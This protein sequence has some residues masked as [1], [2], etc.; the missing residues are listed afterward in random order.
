MHPLRDGEIV[1]STKPKRGVLVRLT[2]EHGRMFIRLD[3]L[4]EG[5]F[6][7]AAWHQR[8]IVTLK[9]VDA[10]QFGRLA[11]DDQE[12]AGLGYYILSRLYAFKAMNEGP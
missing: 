1:M 5:Q 2:H 7:P 8:E 11:F 6:Q 12:L 4:Q 9:E 3:D 10:A